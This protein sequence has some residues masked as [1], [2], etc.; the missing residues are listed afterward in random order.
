M[1]SVQQ[2]TIELLGAGVESV[3]TELEGIVAAKEQQKLA[4]AEEKG[5][6]KEEDFDDDFDEHIPPW[7]RGFKDQG[8]QA[9]TLSL[10]FLSNGAI[11]RRVIEDKTNEGLREVVREELEV[12]LDKVQI[13][14][15]SSAY[16][17]ATR[18][19]EHVASLPPDSFCQIR[20][21]L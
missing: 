9:E 21:A 14:H 12:E 1:A 16:P 15:S 18:R 11:T 20:G 19:D 5:N 2:A 6:K 10:M 4:E 17:F 3:L 8:S 7:M 13:N